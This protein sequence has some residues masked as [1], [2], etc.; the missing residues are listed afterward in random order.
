[1]TH[2]IEIL[3]ALHEPIDVTLQKLSIFPAKGTRQIV[4]TYYYDPLRNVLGWSADETGKGRFK[5]GCR[6]RE[7]N[8]QCFI[9]YKTNHF[10]GDQW[11]YADEHE[12]VVSNA[13]TAKH[14]FAALGLEELVTVNNTRY[15]FET[16]LYEIVVEDVRDLGVFLEV[17]YTGPANDDIQAV[18][19][20][21]FAFIA[22]LGLNVSE[23]STL[24]KP[25]MM[26]LKSTGQ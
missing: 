25:E 9:T 16:E 3:V 8:D 24:G 15:V 11:L 26:Y 2:E 17:E 10:D 22:G 5:A 6:I 23:E 1:M 21:L 13:A 12:M 20:G 4:D 19:A 14:I 7:Q 18:R